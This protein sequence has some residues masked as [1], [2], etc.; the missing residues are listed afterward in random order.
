MES[1]QASK[2]RFISAPTLANTLPK[3]VQIPCIFAN[4]IKQRRTNLENIGRKTAKCLQSN[5]IP[6][7]VQSNQTNGLRKNLR[8]HKLDEKRSK[9]HKKANGKPCRIYVCV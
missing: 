2:F 4:T 3:A 8:I 5:A 7:T 9:S 1:T 6:R